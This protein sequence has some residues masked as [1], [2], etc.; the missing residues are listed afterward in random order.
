MKPL[1]ALR[2]VVENH[3]FQI[4]AL[5]AMDPPACSGFRG[6]P[7]GKGKGVPGHAPPRVG[8]SGSRAIRWLP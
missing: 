7:N 3:L 5:L 2:D 6:G 8:G 1:A 4:V